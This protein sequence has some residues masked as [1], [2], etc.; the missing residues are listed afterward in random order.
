MKKSDLEK[1]IG[2]ILNEEETFMLSLILL[3]H[4]HTDDKYKDLSELIFLFDNYKGFKQFI[5][6]YE[7]KTITI[8]TVMELKQALRLLDLFQKVKIDNKDFDECY[9]RLKLDTLNLTKD[10]CKQELEK[11]NEYLHKDGTIT[12]KQL[13]KLTK[14]K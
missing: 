4:M 2:R 7:G 6:F 12:L 10:Y 8:P 9:K 3:A 13:R 14:L 1:R 5:K 11:F